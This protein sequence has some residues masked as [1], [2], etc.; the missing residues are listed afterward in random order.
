MSPSGT[1]SG[2]CKT[3]PCRTFAYA[4]ARLPSGGELVLQDGTYSSAISWT[5]PAGSAQIPSGAAGTPTVVRAQNPGNVV[6][7]GL[8]IGRSTR[9]DSYITVKGITF[10]G[11]GS[12]YNS[13]FVTIKD[14]G[15]HGGLGIGTNDHEYGNT[16]NLIEDVWV[17]AAEQRIIVSNY[18]A[19]RNVWRRVVVRG[20]G[21]SASACLGSGN[22]NVGITVYNSHDVSLQNVV[23]L[24][25]LLLGGAGP[26][27]DFANAQHERF[28]GDTDRTG[29]N[30]WL[31]TISVNAPDTGYYF[32]L[33]VGQTLA[34]TVRVRDIAAVGAAGGGFNL[35]REG[36]G[37]VLNNVLVNVKA[38]DGIRVAPEMVASGRTG[39]LS[40]AIV[41][42]TGTRGINSSYVANRVAVDGTWS[43]GAFNQTTPTD[44]FSGNPM[45]S[46]LLYPTRIEAGSA[47]AA[48]GFN[49]DITKRIGADGSRFGQPGYNTVTSVE[50]WPW[51][52]EARIKQQMCASTTR[53]FCAAG[54]RL[55]GV[56]P[57]TLSSYIWEMLGR[58][59][60]F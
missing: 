18:R 12:L 42:G 5:G 57:I 27:G 25:R 17:W 51:P 28:A 15:F 37:N 13:S 50:L 8:F 7:P 29:R 52:N 54:A 59:S 41:T 47:L 23:V 1:D 6:V 19:D 20:D 33:D 55:D 48:A 43:G 4:F 32:E 56:N 16:D 9:K 34:P 46:G 26:Y 44:I 38:G 24:D 3:S 30:E 45:T 35:A 22:P 60:P 11:G 49:L 14:S 39:T 40:N 31:G 21:C 2:D 36:T 58:P 53:G 10:E